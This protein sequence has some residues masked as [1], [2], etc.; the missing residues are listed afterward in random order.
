MVLR[1]RQYRDYFDWLSFWLIVT[2][3]CMGLMAIFSATYQAEDF[4][5]LFFKKQSFG[6]L[7]G[8]L[9]YGYCATIDTQRAI[10]AGYFAYFALLIL[11][12]ITLLK[13]SVG[14]GAQRWIDLKIVRFQPSELA[15]L[16]LPP[17]ITY[18]LQTHDEEYSFSFN[19][20]LPLLGIIGL[21]FLVVLKQ[22]DLGTALVIAFSGM[23]MLWYAGLSKRFF[24][25]SAIIVGL[26]APL[27]YQLLKPYQ[28]KRIEVFL[29]AGDSKKERYHIEQS[30]I[31]I[32]S[33]GLT[34]KGFLQGTQNKL[35]FLPESRTDFIFAV[36]CEEMG[37]LGALLLLALYIALIIRTLLRI[38]SLQN[39]YHQLL[40]LGLIAPIAFSIIVNC[41][42]VTGLLPVVGI[43]LPFMSYGVTHLWMTFAIMGLINGITTRNDF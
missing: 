16:L 8:L 30:M 11:L 6:F 2:I 22:P 26:S 3:S 23:V 18:Y 24:I 42:M 33:G 37:L 9:I 38:Y 34:G 31:A 41:G 15:K 4:F 19:D 29:G 40:C 35:A 10:R 21:S 14:M 36:L 17:F 28:K 43:P 32:G 1:Q 5:S 25:I 20:F 39:F 7:S 27:L 12:L 13:G